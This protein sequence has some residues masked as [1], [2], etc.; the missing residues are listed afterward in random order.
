MQSLCASHLGSDFGWV[1]ELQTPTVKK[2]GL[3]LWT[4]AVCSRGGG[5]SSIAPKAPEEVSALEVPA[6][7]H[8][9][10]EGRRQSISTL[11]PALSRPA[12]EWRS[13]LA[14][15]I[16]S[17][18]RPKLAH[19]RQVPQPCDWATKMK[20]YRPTPAHTTESLAVIT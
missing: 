17:K 15:E 12:Q 3:Q 8:N 4:S 13:L 20:Y 16:V 9:R 14:W 6:A 10:D 11:G 2:K 5:G 7:S 18:A 19:H 1:A